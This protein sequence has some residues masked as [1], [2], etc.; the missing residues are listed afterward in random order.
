ME[1]RAPPG[2]GTGQAHSAD[3]PDGIQQ[4]RAAWCPAVFYFWGGTCKHGCRA[5]YMPLGMAGDKQQRPALR[6]CIEPGVPLHADTPPAAAGRLLTQRRTYQAYPSCQPGSLCVLS[7]P[8]S[9]WDRGAGVSF[10]WDSACAGCC[11]G[12]SWP[13]GAAGLG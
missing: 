8:P 10:P 1:K 7:V 5:P 11:A 6:C 2:G 9:S 12:W 13:H 3:P 4:R